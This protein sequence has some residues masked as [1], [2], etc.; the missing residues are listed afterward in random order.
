MDQTFTE[1]TPSEEEMAAHLA[2]HRVA[3][4]V[5]PCTRATSEI[6]LNP[7]FSNDLTYECE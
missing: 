4:L 2:A 3:H 5:A 6:V 7:G 1:V